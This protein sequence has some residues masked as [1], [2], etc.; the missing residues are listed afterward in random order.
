MTD[1]ATSLQTGH[2]LIIPQ[3]GQTVPDGVL[4][5][6][7]QRD[8][9]TVTETSIP[10][11][12]P[13]SLLTAYVETTPA[14][15]TGLAFANGGTSEAIVTLSLT[16]VAGEDL[17]LTTTLRL[18]ANGH[19]ASFLREI[20]EFA[21]LPSEFRGVLHVTSN[22]A[23]PISAIT[24]R[25][26]YN[27]R[28]DFIVSTIQLLDEHTQGSSELLFPHLAD[29][30]GYT[31]DFVLFSASG[32]ASGTLQFNTPSGKPLALQLR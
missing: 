3:P 29:G 28:G 5:F 26:R 25:S 1:A 17:G 14:L 22:A 2:V 31:T 20:P 15:Q 7:Y 24:L 13:A 12:E 30:A 23:A 27:E 19:I 16:N 18:P 8:G 10:A 6:S 32:P 21:S 4:V 11:V 9:I